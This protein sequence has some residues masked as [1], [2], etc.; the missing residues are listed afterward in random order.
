[1]AKR[2]KTVDGRALYYANLAIIAE[3][4]ENYEDAARQWRCASEA[5]IQAEAV[6]LYEEAAKRCERR[7]RVKLG[8]ETK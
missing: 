5:T 4:T 7:A 2:G 3:K 6:G 8:E 1:M